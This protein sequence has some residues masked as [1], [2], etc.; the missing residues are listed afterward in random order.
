MT[1]I[2][3][4]ECGHEISSMA[5]ACPSCGCPEGGVSKDAVTTVK[6]EYCHQLIDANLT[7]CPLCGIQVFKSH[8]S[9][10]K[11]A[12]P[13]PPVK[14]LKT[15]L[16]TGSALALG[17]GGILL[18]FIVAT[19]VGNALDH[20]QTTYAAVA[21]TVASPT[22]TAPVELSPAVSSR[23]T[24]EQVDSAK[25]VMAL[26]VQDSKVY[27]E[28]PHLVVEMGNYMEDRNILFGYCRAI[29]NADAVLEGKSRPIY[30]HDPG[31]KMVATAQA[32]AGVQ[33]KD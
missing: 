4:V 16:S 20:T 22:I 18:I 21:A 15:K 32:G 7:T 26:V 27:S 29:A 6:C 11:T 23:F 12:A 24:K 1:L 5:L 14:G 19:S 31:G 3:C 17:L 28:G 2:N 9:S 33:L 10:N 30:F 13:A 8:R 25:K